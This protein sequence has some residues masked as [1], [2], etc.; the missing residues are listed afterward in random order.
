MHV[1]KDR[2][3]VK[4]RPRREAGKISKPDQQN[5]H[6]RQQ[7]RPLFFDHFETQDKQHARD[8]ADIGPDLPPFR[9]FYKA[10]KKIVLLRPLQKNIV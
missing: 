4:N 1:R 5:E 6:R 3:A 9:I 8:K 10:L 2:A 7:E